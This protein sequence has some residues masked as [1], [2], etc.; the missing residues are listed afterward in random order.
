MVK[1]IIYDL[2]GTL[3]DSAKIVSK[4][5]NQMRT[6]IGL[7]S[8]TIKQ[9][10]PWLSMGG[11]DLIANSLEINSDRVHSYLF[12]FRQ[13]YLELETPNESLYP[14]IKDVLNNL[15]KTGHK[16]AVCTNKPRVLAEKV[17]RETQ[18]HDFF[19]YINAGGDLPY[20]KPHPDNLVSCL[21]FFDASSQDAILVG[22]SKVDQELGKATNV[23]FVQYLPGYDDGIKLIEPQMKIDHHSKLLDVIAYS[24]I[25]SISNI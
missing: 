5:I 11:E 7:E 2:D 8:L 1:L 15:L 21:S 12:E 13:R 3:I 20:K 4:I 22:D 24:N 17:L 18:L 9:L 25:Y 10:V 16:L 14:G 23:S 6:E 19:G